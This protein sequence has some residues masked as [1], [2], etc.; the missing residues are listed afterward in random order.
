MGKIIIV[1]STNTDMV[2][3]SD[4]LPLPGETVVGGSFFM[5][6]GGKGAN[7]AVASARLGAQTLFVTKTG[8]DMFGRKSFSLFENEGIGT[9]FVFSDPTEASGVALIMVDEHGENSIV[10]ASGANAKLLPAD[11]EKARKEIESSDILLMQLEIPMESVETA[12]KI[13]Y[14]SNVKVVLNPAPAQAL[15]ESLLACLYLVTPNEGE[16]EL[17]SGVKITDIASAE[18]AARVI[19]SKGV[20]NVIITLGSKGSFVL[21]GNEAYMME[22]YKVQTVDTTAAGDTFNGAL[23]V[24]LTEGKSI[25]DAVDFASKA[26]AIGVTRMGALSSIPTRKEVDCFKI[27][28]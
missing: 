22:A 12:A 2:V 24:A 28:S 3:K 15:P 16:A 9:Q 23:C 6:P 1:G 26:S 21:E 14:D 10:V 25:R 8:N 5:D 7:Q 4:R 17:L 27:E 11:V 20:K 19:A 13:A 18:K